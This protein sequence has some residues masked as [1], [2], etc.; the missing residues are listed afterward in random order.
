MA[1]IRCFAAL[2][3]TW[4]GLL[5]VSAADVGSSGTYQSAG[6]RTSGTGSGGAMQQQQQQPQNAEVLPTF[7]DG[8]FSMSGTS[9]SSRCEPITI[10]LCKDIQYNETIMPNLLHHQKQEDAALEVHQF[11]P[12]V[13]VSI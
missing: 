9:R 11:F 10:P 1:L 3:M 2:S 6:K 12:L 13:K 4:I 5:L 8:D 7:N